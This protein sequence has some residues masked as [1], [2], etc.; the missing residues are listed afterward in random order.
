[1]NRPRPSCPVTPP[2]VILLIV[3]LSST[4]GRI[5][6]SIQTSHAQ[7]SA[8]P[9]AVRRA[10]AD[11]EVDALVAAADVVVRGRVYSQHS[12]WNADQSAILTDSRVDVH[13]GVFGS[14]SPTVTVR[15]FGGELPHEGIGM[16]VSHA[17]SLR[18]GEE[19]VLFL[20]RDGPQYTISLGEAGLFNVH[21]QDVLNQYLATPISLTGLFDA[22]SATKLPPD[23]RT[24]EAAVGST[25][26]AVAGYVHH[27]LHWPG[28]NPVVPFYVNPVSAQSG[29]DDGSQDD[30]LN[31][32]RAAAD[33]WTGV[34]SAKFSFEYAGITGRQS[35]GYNGVNELVF[36]NEA[37]HSSTLGQSR[38]WYVIASKEIIE[39]DIWLN[40]A[41]DFD[42]TGALDNAET[43]LQ[44]V[45]LHELGHWLAL[46]HDD[47]RGAIM[48]CALTRGVLKRQLHRNDS[49]G[50]LAIYPCPNN[51]CDVTSTP[52]VTPAYTPSSTPT[53]TSTPTPTPTFTSTTA[54]GGTIPSAPTSTPTATRQVEELSRAGGSISY[55][56]EDGET[57]LTLNCPPG[58][59][60]ETIQVTYAEIDALPDPPTAGGQFAQRRFEL[61]AIRNGES[62]ER[63]DF[64]VPVTFTMTYPQ[65]AG[66]D[67]ERLMLFSP[68]EAYQDWTVAACGAVNRDP[69][70]NEISLNV[71]HLSE[72][73]LFTQLVS[74]G[75]SYFLPMVRR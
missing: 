73:A 60:D 50:I 35:T 70:N 69:V 20:Q 55:E 75:S 58:A 14:T 16:A 2:I 51:D 72:F 23:W 62:V 48:Y 10:Q 47:E 56:D 33:T 4:V 17:P 32:I 7:I 68:D 71:C 11:D 28:D 67:E 21:G 12:F 57:T 13:Y 52:T 34:S 24:R 64:A 15:T 74:T 42:A 8:T 22:I 29:P 25:L 45:A 36:I 54:P 46:D 66:W 63:Y 61:N 9:S 39:A 38:L 49:D 1:M 6:F 27:G 43:D 5:L 3:L 65:P 40:D 37:G 59:V 41:F 44:S 19:V 31:A 30:F 18:V 26:G 53:R